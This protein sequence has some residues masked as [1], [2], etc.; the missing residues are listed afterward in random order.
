ME[1]RHRERQRYLPVYRR[2]HGGVLIFDVD[3]EVPNQPAPK[4]K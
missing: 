3:A 2:L 4:G 1:Q